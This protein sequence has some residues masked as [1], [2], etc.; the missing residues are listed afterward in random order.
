[1]EITVKEKY[2]RTAPRKLRL[3]SDLIR[4]WNA[5]KALNQLKFIPKA[6]AQDLTKAIQAAL[7][8]AKESN[9]NLETVYIKTLMINEGPSLKRRVYKSRG[10]AS[11]I[12][13]HM[14]HIILTLAE[15]AEVPAE[16]K[17]TKETA[18]ES[19]ELNVKQGKEK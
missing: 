3:V 16:A 1:M 8:A 5:Q 11:Q 2:N 17:E 10:Q 6:A 18:T 7:G 4:G 12:K 15:R 14:S 9:L 19:P 13:K